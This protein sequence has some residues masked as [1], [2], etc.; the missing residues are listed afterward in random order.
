MTL[1]YM[2]VF[3][4]DPHENRGHWRMIIVCW[5]VVVESD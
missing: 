1:W 3:L 2:A 4:G 5:E